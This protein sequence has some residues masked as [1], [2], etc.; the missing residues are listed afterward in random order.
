[1][2]A[3]IVAKAYLL[4]TYFEARNWMDHDEAVAQVAG[5]T[6][7]EVDTVQAVIDEEAA[8]C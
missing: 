4:A 3:L 1:M 6:G 7:H 8:T 2:G 5:Q